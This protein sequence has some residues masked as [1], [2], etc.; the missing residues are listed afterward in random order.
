[1]MGAVSG[2]RD[3]RSA[4][5]DATE[6]LGEPWQRFRTFCSTWLRS[7]PSEEGWEATITS[8]ER[9]ALHAGA[10]L[11]APGGRDLEPWDYDVTPLD[12]CAFAS[13][14][15]DGEHFNVLLEPPSRGVIVLTAPMA[16]DQPNVVVGESIDDFLGLAVVG[17]LAV[18]P[19]LAY[20]GL[21]LGSSDIAAASTAEPDSIVHALRNE[22][23]IDPW[24]DVEMRLQVLASAHLERLRLTA[25]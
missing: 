4:A 21:A 9:L 13:T 6:V 12:S 1:M 19:N 14:G 3:R 7:H 5:A 11:H 24:P 2:D 22:L 8:S 15:V 23:G 25:P 17:G 20:R 18:I 16:S 10:F